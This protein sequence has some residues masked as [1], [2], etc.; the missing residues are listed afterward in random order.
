MPNC[1][2]YAVEGDFDAVLDFV[3]SDLSCRVFESYSDYDAD[4]REFTRTSE[5][6][7]RLPLGKPSGTGPSVAL[8][9]WPIEASQNVSFKRIMLNPSKCDGHTF[10]YSINGWG[11]IQLYLGGLS[12]TGL[13]HSHTNH[14]SKARARKW[15]SNYIELGPIEAW[16]WDV[17]ES[18]SRKLN[19]HIRRNLAITQFESRPVLPDAARLFREGANAV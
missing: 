9:L 7:D 2:F 13:V 3:F 12:P 15:Q 4:L 1:D 6:Y 10:R 8:Q 17:V 5:I 11:L 19:H 14:N 18:E 16:N